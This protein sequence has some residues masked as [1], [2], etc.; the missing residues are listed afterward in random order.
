MRPFPP[1]RQLNDYFVKDPPPNY[2][3]IARMFRRSGEGLFE[4]IIDFG[5]GKVQQ[6]HVLRSTGVK[7]LDDAGAVTFL[8]WRA[9]PR[10]LRRAVIPLEFRGPSRF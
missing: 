6:V 1:G 3:E 4:L 5:T 7:I 2:P 8:Q 10:L 9:K